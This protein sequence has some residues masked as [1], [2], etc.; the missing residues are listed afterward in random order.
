MQLKDPRES[1]HSRTEETCHIP[2]LSFSFLLTLFFV[3]V[4]DGFL[5]G[6]GVRLA[7]AGVT[8]TTR[9]SLYSILLK[10]IGQVLEKPSSKGLCSER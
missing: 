4:V 10:S 7:G 3:V 8:P 2:C 1:T 9:A 5:G 6:G